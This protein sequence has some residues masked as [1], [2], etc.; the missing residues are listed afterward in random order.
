M[1][2]HI[3]LDPA[4]FGTASLTLRHLVGIAITE[5]AAVLPRTRDYGR[6]G[7]WETKKAWQLRAVSKVLHDNGIDYSRPATGPMVKAA[8]APS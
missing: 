4:Y 8:E 3:V 1:P 7:R 6:G 2:D 5:P